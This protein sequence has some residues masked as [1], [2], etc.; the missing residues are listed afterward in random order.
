MT[1]LRRT[2]RLAPLSAKAEAVLAYIRAHPGCTRRELTI[3]MDWSLAISENIC[4]RLVARDLVREEEERIGETAVWR[5][6][7]WAI[8]ETK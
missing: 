6:C 7:Y 2:P 5:Y 8:E 3:A 1:S 4:W